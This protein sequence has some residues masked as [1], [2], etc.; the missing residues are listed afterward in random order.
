MIYINLVFYSY[1]KITLIIYKSRIIIHE[2]L[3]SNN[4]KIIRKKCQVI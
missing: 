2:L 3:Q 1:I 4:T